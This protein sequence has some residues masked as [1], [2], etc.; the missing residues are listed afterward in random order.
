MFHPFSN[1]HDTCI[2]MSFSMEV[3]SNLFICVRKNLKHLI[4]LNYELVYTKQK[5]VFFSI[6]ANETKT[7][8]FL[9]KRGTHN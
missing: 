2:Y 1:T 8:F 4:F 6:L 5:Q 7:T 9:I 3:A